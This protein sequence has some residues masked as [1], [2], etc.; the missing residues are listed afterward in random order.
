[1]ES[2]IRSQTMPATFTP[3]QNCPEDSDA[4]DAPE[5]DR[6]DSFLLSRRRS[7]VPIQPVEPR[8]DQGR[9]TKEKEPAEADP[10]PQGQDEDCDDSEEPPHGECKRSLVRLVPSFPEDGGNVRRDE[11]ADDTHDEGEDEQSHRLPPLS[12][13]RRAR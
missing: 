5:A 3:R 9:E 1:M 10:P 11:V 8:G 7:T 4:Q 12:A 6:S 13:R 2:E